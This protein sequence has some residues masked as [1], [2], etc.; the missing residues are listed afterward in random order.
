MLV[1]NGC[2]LPGD[3]LRIKGSGA[4]RVARGLEM[5]GFVRVSAPPDQ[6]ACVHVTAEGRA[7]REE[8]GRRLTRS[9]VSTEVDSIAMAVDLG[10]R[11]LHLRNGNTIRF[12]PSGPVCLIRGP[13]AEKEK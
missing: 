4:H 2:S 8:L 10:P 6:K 5:L 9:I 13:V 7:K 12:V 3:G 1:A 11:T